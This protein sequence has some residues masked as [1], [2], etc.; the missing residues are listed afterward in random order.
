VPHAGTDVDWQGAAAG[1]P[2]SNVIAFSVRDA[3]SRVLY[4]AFNPYLEPVS[5]ALP[6]A[7]P[8]GIWRLVVDTSR[9]PPDDI[10][11]E[12]P[13]LPLGQPLYELA[14]KAGVLM[15]GAGNSDG[16][17][18]GMSMRGGTGRAPGAMRGPMRPASSFQ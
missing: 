13:L 7:G 2:P 8:S 5:V 10:N 1:L 11:L 3:G 17:G 6:G 14:P 9:L 15:V 16:Q 18:P 12:G 4:V